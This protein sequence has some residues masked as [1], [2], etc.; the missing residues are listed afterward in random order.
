MRAHYLLRQ[1]LPQALPEPVAARLRAIRQLSAHRE[2]V[3]ACRQDLVSWRAHPRTVPP[4]PRQKTSQ[5]TLQK[6][7]TS[8]L[9]PRSRQPR[10]LCDCVH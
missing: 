8:D 6:T 3:S 7:V 4:A 2:K 9:I 1:L 5:E 10:P